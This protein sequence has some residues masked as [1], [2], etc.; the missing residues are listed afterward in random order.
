MMN[1][2]IAT[3]KAMAILNLTWL[4]EDIQALCYQLQAPDN[5]GNPK[6]IQTYYSLQVMKVASE[7]GTFQQSLKSTN[8]GIQRM[9]KTIA[10]ES[11]RMKTVVKQSGISNTMPSKTFCCQ[12]VQTLQYWY[13][14]AA[15]LT[16]NFKT[17][18]AGSQAGMLTLFKADRKKRCQ[19]LVHGFR[20]N[21]TN[22][23]WVTMNRRL[24]SLIK[25]RKLWPMQLVWIPR[26]RPWLTK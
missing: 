20:H 11:G 16:P 8:T 1:L 6:K 15:K 21:R 9:V 13:G 2:S 10:L 17:T 7:S 4:Y 3:L 18:L 12:L 19:R 5:P 25:L 23:L 26:R 22:S 14:T 24:H